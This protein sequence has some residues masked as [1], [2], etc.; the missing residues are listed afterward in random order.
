MGSIVGLIS[1]NSSKCVELLLH[2]WNRGDCVAFIDWRI[3]YNRII[4]I[5]A[6]CNITECYVSEY[7]YR[8]WETSSDFLTDRPKAKLNIVF[9]NNRGACLLPTEIYEMFHENYS[10]TD[11][12]VLFSSGTTGKSKGIIL[13]HYAI[14]TNADAVIKYM[15]LDAETT[16]SIVKSLSHSS[17]IV[18]E[19]LVALKTKAKVLLSPTITSPKASLD[20]IEK[21]GVSL[22]CV[23]PTLLKIYADTVKKL[24]VNVNNL[25]VIYVSGSI[26]SKDLLSLV[27]EVFLDVQILNVYGLTE[28]GPRVTAQV[29]GQQ[30]TDGSV[31]KAIDGVDVKVIDTNGDVLPY[32]EKGIIHVKTKS[33]FSGYI[34]DLKARKSFYK[35][36][37]N[38]GDIGYMN[39]DGELFI[40]GRWDDMILQGAHNVFPDEIE[41]LIRVKST[42]VKCLVFGVKDDII[43]ERIICYY[44]ADKDCSNEL[45]DVCINNLASYEIPKEFIRVDM[46]PQTE[47]GKVSRKIAA[48]QYRKEKA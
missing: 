40:L 7:I 22:M 14:N 1:D 21:Y 18:G 11:A 27:R 32:G 2:I 26:L 39:E 6:D 16:I 36:W 25:K 3:P 8:K 24:K 9:E 44:V 5:F 48:A 47:N 15:G 35:D 12:L 4:E 45:M 17:T 42:V 46:I 28:A 31:G 33:I 19:L 13:S 43:G 29:K 38:T 34:L 20:N 37:F 41:E 30:W 10:D 23:N